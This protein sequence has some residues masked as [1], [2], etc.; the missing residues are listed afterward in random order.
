MYIVL[1]FELPLHSKS[2]NAEIKTH[3]NEKGT[4]FYKS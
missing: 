2:N 4:K 3:E 1:L